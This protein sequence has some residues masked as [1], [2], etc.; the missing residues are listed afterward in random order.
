[1]S[2]L[3]FLGRRDGVCSGVEQ[4]RAPVTT[5]VLPST[6]MCV[7]TS[8]C[9]RDGACSCVTLCVGDAVR[10]CARVTLC[11][12]VQGTDGPCARGGRW[13]CPRVGAHG[14]VPQRGGGAACPCPSS[15]GCP[16]WG[17]HSCPR[18]CSPDWMISTQR[19]FPSDSLRL[20]G[21][22]EHTWAGGPSVHRGKGG[23]GTRFCCLYSLLTNPSLPDIYFQPVSYQLVTDAANAL[24]IAR[25]GRVGHSG[26]AMAKAL[27]EP[28][29]RQER[30][31]M[32]CRGSPAWPRQEGPVSPCSVQHRPRVPA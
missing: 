12:C 4:L 29:P 27:F 23:H 26:W 21:S 11:V 17:A 24:L 5:S 32:G 8:A 16:A 6:R 10:A 30:G 7:S 14:G 22:G 1:M 19:H 15:P 20:F 3:L 2:R 9:A 13:L 18:G 31:V 25:H 28:C